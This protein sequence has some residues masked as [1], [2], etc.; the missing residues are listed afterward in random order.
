MDSLPG[1]HGSLRQYQRVGLGWIHF[2]QRFGF[3]G[4]LA[5]DMGLGKTIQVLALLEERRCARENGSSSDTLP[6]SLVVMPKS[7]V[8]NWIQE[9]ERFTPE[10]R[11]L[12]HTG[13]ERI[14]SLK[15]FNDYDAVF[16]TYGTLRR[17]ITAEP[18]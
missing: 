12:D 5:D 3:G 6:P 8:F 1:F 16:T 4:C 7:L 17:D 9:A 18:W 14:R 13:G 10:L 2:L 11:I 15:H